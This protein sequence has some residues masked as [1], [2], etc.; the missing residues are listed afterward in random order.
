MVKLCDYKKIMDRK[1]IHIATV[2]KENNPNLSVASDVLVIDD[3][4]IIISVNEMTNTQENVLYNPNIV[5]TAFDEELKGIR[6]FGEA[7]FDTAGKYYDMCNKEFFG[8]GE[9]TPFGATKP[10]GVLI[11]KVKKIH[12]YV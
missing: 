10:K 11:V 2:N 8:N 5:I 1:P 12:E 3:E 4:T 6:I 7:S 9:I